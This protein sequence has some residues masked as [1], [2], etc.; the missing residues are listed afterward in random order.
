MSHPKLDLFA[1]SFVLLAPLSACVIL[2]TEPRVPERVPVA[3]PRV[4]TEGY[5]ARPRVGTARDQKQLQA[6]GR[7]Q[8][9]FQGLGPQGQRPSLGAPVTRSDY[10]HAPHID[11]WSGNL[12]Q[13]ERTAAARIQVLLTD[14][15]GIARTKNLG[16]AEL[17]QPLLA[18]VFVNVPE[19]QAKVQVRAY[20]ALNNL[21]TSETETVPVRSNQ[22]AA[23][24]FAMPIGTSGGSLGSRL[25]VQRNEPTGG[26]IS[27][28]WVV[29]A[30]ESPPE[31]PMVGCGEDYVWF[32][33]QIGN[34]V[35]ATVSGWN[36]P[37]SEKY[38]GSFWIEEA[39]G[40]M[41]KNNLELTG[42]V[43]YKDH[44][45]GTPIGV[46]RAEYLLVFD[47]VANRLLGARND[48]RGW[49]VPYIEDCEGAPNEDVTV[50][51]TPA[52]PIATRNSALVSGSQGL[53]PALPS[54]SP[55]PS[56]LKRV[57]GTVYGPD[58]QPVSTGTILIQTLDLS[59]SR[60]SVPIQPDGRY[61]ADIPTNKWVEMFT[62]SGNLTGVYWGIFYEILGET[63]QTR[64]LWLRAEEVTERDTT[65]SE[66]ISPPSE[67]NTEDTVATAV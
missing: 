43:T 12:W 66:D 37:D 21:I 33:T 67:T 59:T 38:P 29:N 17:K 6:T 4:R 52:P 53:A 3:A 20:D 19:G 35:R 23:L 40:T 49:A 45:E 25:A 27:G 60:V 57:E 63:S 15:A 42:I 36:E 28:Y 58:D 50:P 5:T 41:R 22:L 30:G 39:F 64:D 48:V 34:N 9:T 54:T 2:G 44:P 26:N 56:R 10:R 11:G 47:P 55:A 51:P 61:A 16:A 24:S 46:E 18:M 32:V 8:V 7:V 62:T 1:L 65:A 13:T 31:Y 14:S